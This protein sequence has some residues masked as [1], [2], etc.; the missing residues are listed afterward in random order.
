MVERHA[1][2]RLPGKPLV[3]GLVEETRRD[4]GGFPGEGQLVVQLPTCWITELE[5]QMSNELSG[6]GKKQPSPSTLLKNCWVPI[7][8]PHTRSRSNLFGPPLRPAGPAPKRDKIVNR[9]FAN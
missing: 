4:A 8:S 1:L 5:W 3:R 6:H 9:I 2:M 7:T